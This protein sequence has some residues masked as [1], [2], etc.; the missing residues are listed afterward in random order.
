[1]TTI[2]LINN[3]FNACIVPL[4]GGLTLFIIKLLE[5]KSQ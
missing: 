2:E 1:M 3:I 5:K 4:L